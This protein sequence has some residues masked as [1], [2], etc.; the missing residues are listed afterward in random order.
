MWEYSLSYW[1]VFFVQPIAADC[2]RGRGGK[3]SRILGKKTQ[4]LIYN[5][6]Y[7][8]YRFGER[9]DSWERGS[10]FFWFFSYWLYVDVYYILSR[11][12]S[13]LLIWKGKF[14]FVQSLMH[15]NWPANENNP[16][17]TTFL[18]CIQQKKYNDKKVFY[19][20]Q[21]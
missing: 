21:Y 18:P 16:S 1:L 10:F 14:I 5:T 20:K 3:L 4:Y 19:S 7:Y 15:N 6:L 17:S 8:M 11:Y 13:K 2:W 9:R 12:L